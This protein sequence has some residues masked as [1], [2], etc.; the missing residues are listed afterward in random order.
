[1]TITP[2]LKRYSSLIRRNVY[3]YAYENY[4]MKPLLEEIDQVWVGEIFDIAD[5]DMILHHDLLYDLQKCGL[6]Q[7]AKVLYDKFVILPDVF[8]IRQYPYNTFENQYDMDRENVVI[9]NGKV[10]ELYV[11]EWGYTGAVDYQSTKK[12]YISFYNYNGKTYAFYNSDNVNIFSANNPTMKVLAVYDEA[13]FMYDNIPGVNWDNESLNSFHF[14]INKDN[15]VIEDGDTQPH[16]TLYMHGPRIVFDYEN[17]VTDRVPEIPGLLSLSKD[18]WVQEGLFNFQENTAFIHS[19]NMLLSNTAI[20]FYKD[21][22]YRIVNMYLETN[23][24]IIK[25]IDKH[26]IKLDKDDTIKKIVVFTRPFIYED[27]YYY[28]TDSL[29]YKANDINDLAFL[30]LQPYQSHTNTLMS[31]LLYDSMTL[32]DI[33]EYGYKYDLD[34]LKTIQNCFPRYI[35]VAPESYSVVKTVPAF[36]GDYAIIEYDRTRKGV[37]WDLINEKDP[38]RPGHIDSAANYQF[39]PAWQSYKNVWI[40][41]DVG[42]IE[43]TGPITDITMFYTSKLCITFP[44]RLDLY[45]NVFI[46]KELVMSDYSIFHVG[47]DT[48]V[49]FI[50]TEE[51]IKKYVNTSFSL[52]NPEDRAYKANVSSCKDDILNAITDLDIVLTEYKV[53]NSERLNI[54]P[55]RIFRTPIYR[56]ELIFDSY[57]YPESTENAY[58][59]R[60]FVNGKL[61]A[62]TFTFNG[63]G[64]AISPYLY[65]RLDGLQLFDFDNGLTDFTVGTSAS[66]STIYHPNYTLD[67]GTL[68]IY[69]NKTDLALLINRT[70]EK[71]TGICRVNFGDDYF[72]ST[73]DFTQNTY[74]EEVDFDGK[75]HEYGTIFFDKFGYLCNEYV[76]VL[77]DKYINI[78][79]TYKYDHMDYMDDKVVVHGF[80][81]KLKNDLRGID[82]EIDET[83]INW[84]YNMGS[85]NERCMAVDS[86]VDLFKPVDP[87]TSRP[88]PVTEKPLN[89]LLGEKILTRYYLSC[90]GRIYSVSDYAAQTAILSGTYVNTD[91]TLG[92]I[93]DVNQAFIQENDEVPDQTVALNRFFVSQCM[94]Y[95]S[96]LT[97]CSPDNDIYIIDQGIYIDSSITY[98]YEYDQA[99]INFYLYNQSGTVSDV[100]VLKMNHD[101][102]NNDIY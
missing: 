30:A 43:A 16:V 40:Y 26:T 52:N 65:R 101:A 36:G 62:D 45:P 20:I 81:L 24:A 60:M 61:N 71:L 39:I 33:I 38:S 89:M 91:G 64:V 51:I 5:I 50:D 37:T 19:E 80:P 84:A 72:M 10:L 87:L 54:Q 58:S 94:M 28:R 15:Y 21:D 34:V 42:P 95:Q 63:S 97:T 46:N 35:H 32:E 11:K 92:T 6:Y 85:Y 68:S 78:T 41:D 17:N 70:T 47:L 44:N 57:T 2:E 75:I 59:G 4:N 79:N 73:Y 93:P 12:E 56:G 53:L 82:L 100:M 7:D 86:I 22:T 9:I 18:G 96:L 74:L 8:S 67:D 31:G 66:P 83:R 69:Q 77:S 55:G 3:K 90:L 14:H 76:T 27:A 25:K 98:S 49:I 23:D 88:V 99:K 102:F 48:C 13:N 1:M 29:Y